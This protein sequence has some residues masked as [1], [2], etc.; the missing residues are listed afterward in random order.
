MKKITSFLKKFSPGIFYSLVDI[1]QK[2]RIKRDDFEPLHLMIEVTNDCNLKC[3]MCGNYLMKSERGFMDLALFRNIISQCTGLGIGDISLHT[4]GEPLLC[5]DIIEMIKIAKKAGLR[6]LL[7]TN[8]VL[9]DKRMSERIVESGLDV[10]RYSIEGTDKK[11]Y[12]RIRRGA[13]FEKVID[14]IRYFKMIRDRHGKI[15]RIIINS[16]MMRSLLGRAGEFYEQWGQFSDEIF[17]S[18]IGNFN[19]MPHKGIE[20]ELIKMER[21]HKRKICYMLWETMIVQWNGMV[22]ACCMDFGN[23]FIVGDSNK[24]SLRA[25]WRNDAYNRIRQCH[26]KGDL[27]E[28]PLCNK[29]DSGNRNTAYELFTLN[30][31]LRRKSKIK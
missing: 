22:T 16:V 6:V 1:Q 14:N 18:Y 29:C 21:P 31:S 7:S 2:N 8:A 17:F 4:I 27:D 10:I 15:P 20:N 25:I 23:D 24:H 5:P 3:K 19:Q 9:L 30:G 11:S 28:F 13:N 12:E 26:L